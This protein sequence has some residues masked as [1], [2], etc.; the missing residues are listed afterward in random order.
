MGSGTWSIQR[1]SS[2]N[3]ESSSDNDSTQETGFL[4]IIVLGASGDLAKK[5]TFPALFNLYRQG[6]LQPSE[7]HIFGYARTKIS[8]DDLRNRIRGYLIHGKDAS[9]HHSDTVSNFLQL[10]KYVSGSYDTEEGFKLLDK[11]ISEHESSK[12]SLDGSSRRLFYL[13]LPPS[14]YPS[15]CRMIWQFCMNK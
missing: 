11:E 1:R 14:V 12:K 2:F 3:T 8:D 6:F 9:P 10:I 5:K 7:V 4:S 15:V 13:A